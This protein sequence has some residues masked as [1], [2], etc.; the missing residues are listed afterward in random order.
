[1][2]QEINSIINCKID[3]VSLKFAYYLIV[4][5]NKELK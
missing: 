2:K 4:S 5:S 1:M 3:T